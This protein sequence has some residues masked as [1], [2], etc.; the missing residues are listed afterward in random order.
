MVQA[1]KLTKFG[2]ICNSLQQLNNWSLKDMSQAMGVASTTLKRI[3]DGEARLTPRYVEKFLGAFSL[4]LSD[5]WIE[6]IKQ[7][8][9]DSRKTKK[10]GEKFKAKI[11][12]KEPSYMQGKAA[13]VFMEKVLPYFTEDELRELVEF[14]E[15][16]NYG[17]Q[18][19]KN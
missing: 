18:Q 19:E 12:M 13:K 5:T 1:K 17:E 16:K 2:R 3:M 8:E 7:Q 10:K 6:D 9:I 4:Y 11:V 14:M 15:S